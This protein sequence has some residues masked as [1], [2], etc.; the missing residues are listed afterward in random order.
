M[1]IIFYPS[2][3]NRMTLKQ[4]RCIFNELICKVFL[5]VDLRCNPF[6]IN[7]L[8]HI[9]IKLGMVLIF[10]FSSSII[11]SCSLDTEPEDFIAPQYYYNTVAEC[12][13]A[14][15]AIY[16]K[17]DYNFG[18]LVS[19]RLWADD[20]MY[21]TGTLGPWLNI[22]YS[23]DSFISQ[24]WQ[25]LYD[26]I[27][28]ANMLL[29]NIDRAQ[30]NETQSKRI[31]GEA[32]FLRAYYYFLL[33]Q[34]WG[35]VPLKT[36][37]TASAS[38]IYYVRTPAAE[39]YSFIY[40]EMVEAEG[41]VRPITEYGYAERVSQSAVQ[42]ILARV[43]LFMAGFPNRQTE[44]YGDALKWSEKVIHS[45]I[46]SLNPDYA[47]VFINMIQDK[48]DI[49]ES[50]WEI[51]Y[52]TTGAT[53]SYFELGE[54][55]NLNGITQNIL[56]YGM[57]TGNFTVHYSLWKKYDATDV[58]RDW[59]IAPFSYYYNSTPPLKVVFNTNVV[60]TPNI[61]KF[62]REYELTPV[63]SQQKRANG[64]NWPLLRYAEVLLMAAEA[65]NE[66][67]GPTAKA[68][69]YLNEVRKRAKAP[70]IEGVSGKEDFR[71]IIQDERSRE[72]CFEGLR[73]MDLKR[74]EI[75][76]P[77]M[78]NLATYIRQIGPNATYI[79]RAV[80]ACDNVSEQHYYFPIPVREMNL[81]KLL[82]QN[83]GW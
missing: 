42:G 27:E 33:V 8:R 76:I 78:R 28:R 34:N 81:N 56:G 77:T 45:G 69:Q 35:D 18:N 36:L 68:F 83:P 22:Y 9:S 62:R 19:C 32:K 25:Y 71:T 80:V 52:K 55:G 14:L 43:C 39:V 24:F 59:A 49:K 7:Q 63:A 41:M 66:I 53:D 72:L 4:C 23:S 13:L 58:R 5:Q 44:K 38:D 30:M 16:D 65:E 48:Y 26:G 10:F 12:N 29:A 61:G 60:N 50:I 54:I 57:A 37:P 64:T 3:T 21:S 17:M 46:H 6:T 73:K 51:G 74:W 67:N 11:S 15:T 20:E 47:Q 40:N 79:S 75:M 1:K 31:K 70:L 2:Y 82:T